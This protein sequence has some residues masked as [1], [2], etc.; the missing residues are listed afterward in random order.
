MGSVDSNKC[1]EDR[2][3][4]ALP[5]SGRPVTYHR[6]PA[7]ALVF[8][9]DFD[10]W[11]RDDFRA[12][13]YNEGYADAD[14]DYAGSR[15]AASAELIEKLFGTAC[16][17]LDVLDYGGGD[18]ALA[19]L[20]IS[21]HGMVAEVYD[22]FNPACDIPPHRLFPLITCF[23]VLEHTPDPR[24]TI[25]EIAGLVQADGIVVFS[26]L[27]QP[28]DFLQQGLGWWYVAPR[29][30]HVT[31]YSAQALRAL[32][33]ELGFQLISHGDNLHIAYRTLP[34]FARGLAC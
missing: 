11:D 14:P 21:Q 26:T 29:N 30:G 34:P 16:G 13:I 23:E 7:C 1:C 10:A 19:A 28:D 4:V 6:C 27:L 9:G 5:L 31:L 33:A 18:G 3:R 2:R 8:T 25:F 22:P 12:N 32:W 17:G 24:A 20:L 15:P